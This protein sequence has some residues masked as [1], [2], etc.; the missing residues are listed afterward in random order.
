[1]TEDQ[2]ELLQKAEQSLEA[3]KLL[4]TNSYADYAASRAY[5]TAIAQQEIGKIL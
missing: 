4:L 1:V 3:A 2:R 5:Y